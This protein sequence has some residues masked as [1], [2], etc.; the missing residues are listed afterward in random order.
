MIKMAEPLVVDLTPP[1]FVEHDALLFAGLNERYNSHQPKASMA[2]QWQRFLPYV[3]SVPGEIGRTTYGVLHDGDEDG[4]IE[5]LSAVEV[6]DLASVPGKL[7]TLRVP[8]QSY[9]VFWHRD[10]VSKIRGTWN[11]IWNKWLPESG[12]E[13]AEEAPAF[14][15]YTESF[16]PATGLGGAE[17]WIPIKTK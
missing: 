12:L 4:N 16:D 3:G 6:R 10:H 13:A 14:E 2:E 1:R 8:A 17:I 15:R 9:A 5:Y 11:A 7:T